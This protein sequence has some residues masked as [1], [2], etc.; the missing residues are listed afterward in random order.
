MVPGGRP[1]RICDTRRECSCYAKL[2]LMVVGRRDACVKTCYFSDDEKQNDQEEMNRF[3]STLPTF[4][5]I[6][7]SREDRRQAAAPHLV[8]KHTK[9]RRGCSVRIPEFRPRWFPHV[10]QSQT[11]PH[12]GRLHANLYSSNERNTNALYVLTTKGLILQR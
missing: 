12:S 4:S 6:V 3:S 2:M 8:K 7:V 5:P 9:R 10:R 1:R 11:G